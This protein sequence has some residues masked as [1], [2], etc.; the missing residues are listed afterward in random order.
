MNS[1][2][3]FIKLSLLAF[4]PNGTK[5]TIDKYTITLRRPGLTQ[6]IIRWTMGESRQEIIQIKDHV[7]NMIFLLS[8]GNFKNGDAII[9]C[10]R[11]ALNKLK[12][13]YLET[14]EIK[15]LLQ[16]LEEDLTIFY[17]SKGGLEN[18]KEICR[19]K[20]IEQILGKWKYTN[21][22]FINYNLKCI[23]ELDMN[24]KSE[25]KEELKNRYI[26]IIEEF[27]NKLI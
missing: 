12:V 19:K 10:M 3:L 6:G 4:Y 11:K 20:K 1:I 18:N 15:E 25:L 8:N 2:Y 17:N 9:Y 7:R 14:N 16:V 22:R 23:L 5:I 26:N 24:D 13:C 21:I 27:T